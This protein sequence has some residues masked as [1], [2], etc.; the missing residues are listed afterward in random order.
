MELI[1]TIND[2]KQAVNNF[3][4]DGSVTNIGATIFTTDTAMGSRWHS[5]HQYLVNEIGNKF[6]ASY[7]FLVEFSVNENKRVDLIDDD[8]TYDLDQATMDDLNQ[9]FVNIDYVFLPD[10]PKN[11]YN[12]F[13]NT[14]NDIVDNDLSLQAESKTYLDLL[15]IYLYMRA[16][17]TDSQDKLMWIV[18]MKNIYEWTPK[19]KL[20][21]QK[22][23]DYFSE[24]YEDNVVLAIPMERDEDGLIPEKDPEPAEIKQARLNI[25]NDL[26]STALS[27]IEDVKDIVLDYITGLE[28]L[29]NV[30]M[31]IYD[32]SE[33][34]SAWYQFESYEL[35][36]NNVSTVS[37]VD[38]YQ[39][40]IVD[41]LNDHNLP[42]SGCLWIKIL[43][44]KS[45]SYYEEILYFGIDESADYLIDDEGN[46]TDV[47]GQY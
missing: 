16:A 6:S 20:M 13:A 37:G 19:S 30:R 17:K 28:T 40:E 1:R 32:Q 23:C 24:P 5:G 42:A 36:F 27:T 25:H 15:W 14:F 2:I 10:I 39:L 21:R 18:G 33:E 11:V 7:V 41:N 3:N 44:K 26:R 4:A 31:D 34:Y 9:K 46:L 35:K 8:F 38:D 47:T 22:I 45:E 43:P 29:C 12:S